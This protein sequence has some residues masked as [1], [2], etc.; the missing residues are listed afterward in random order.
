M[1]FRFLIV[2]DTDLW[3][4]A[5]FS[6]WSSTLN[7]NSDFSNWTGDDPD[8]WAVQN[9]DVA[10]YVAENSG[11]ARFVM[12]SGSTALG[13][14]QT[15]LLTH[16]TQ[17]V[18]E[19]KVTASDAP[20]SSFNEDGYFE[21][22]GTATAYPFV[23][24]WEFKADVGY[25]TA[26][27]TNFLAQ[28]DLLFQRVDAGRALDVTFDYI[29]L[30]ANDG[31]QALGWT[32]GTIYE[33]FGTVTTGDFQRTAYFTQGDGGGFASSFTDM[34]TSSTTSSSDPTHAWMKY[35]TGLAEGDY[36]LRYTVSE[37]FP[38]STRNENA[39]RIVGHHGEET[40]MR[41]DAGEHAVQ[42]H[43]PPSGVFE[44][45]TNDLGNFAVSS[46]SLYTAGGYVEVP[47]PKYG[48]MESM[49]LGQVAG[50]STGGEF[51][52]FDR[53]TKKESMRLSW[54]NLNRTQMEALVGF[55]NTS[56]KGMKELFDVEFD[57]WRPTEFGG[58]GGTVK[59]TDTRFSQPRLDFR[60][61]RNG[62]YST[63]L[64]LRL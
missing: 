20:D 5:A 56:A 31:P 58:T 19:Y 43:L 24:P 27:I 53:G 25:H 63:R 54:D 30:R 10:N 3:P 33:K 57:D 6:S 40:L 28:P 4:S 44:L 11:G 36:L 13:I 41:G 60:E 17:Q 18:L 23:S 9:E 16:G 22:A 62:L 49:A 12:D 8:N 64:E 46:F 29:R 61:T 21:L 37:S 26:G 45:R 2:G 1:A 52:V 50:E 47:S 55:F 32:S 14:K 51:Y 15:G 7:S 59:F 35:T 48:N 42:F 39:W 38:F 34:G